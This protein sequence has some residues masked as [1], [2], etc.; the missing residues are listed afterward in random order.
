MPYHLHLK[1]FALN[2]L[3]VTEESVICLDWNFVHHLFY[4]HGINVGNWTA[5]TPTL[6]TVEAQVIVAAYVFEYETVGHLVKLER[7]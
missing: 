1:L 4:C 2:F 6:A 7:L 3:V 5:T